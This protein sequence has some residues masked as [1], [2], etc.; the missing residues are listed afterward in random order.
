MHDEI[1]EIL[2]SNTIMYFI[3]AILQFIN[4]ILQFIQ[5]LAKKLAVSM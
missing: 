4:A 5:W 1:H 3:N 2:D